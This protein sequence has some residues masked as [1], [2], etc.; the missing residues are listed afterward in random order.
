MMEMIISV[1]PR[2]NA[3]KGVA[4]ASEL[5]KRRRKVA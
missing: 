5:R 2:Y 4:F 3:S 1:Q